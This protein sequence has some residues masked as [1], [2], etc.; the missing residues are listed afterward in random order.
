MQPAF[1]RSV[2]NPYRSLPGDVDL[3]EE[4]EV[5]AVPEES[6]QPAWKRTNLEKELEEISAIEAT[7]IAIRQGAARVKDGEL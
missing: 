3:P 2:G 5:S 1:S 6:Y 4:K 7:A